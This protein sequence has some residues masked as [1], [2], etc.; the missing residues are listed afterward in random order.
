MVLINKLI[1]IITS[2]E[3]QF[4]LIVFAVVLGIIIVSTI[5]MS[6]IKKKNKY[7]SRIEKH[8]EF[9]EEDVF[10]DFQEKNKYSD[11]FNRYVKPYIKK[12]PDVFT[13]ILGTTGIDLQE[14][15]RKLLRANVR[16]KT[17]EQMAA[18][19][20]IGL[21]AGVFV[22]VATFPFMDYMGL[23]IGL[24]F[25]F[26]LSIIPFSRLDSRYNKRKDEIKDTLPTYLRLMANATSV[27]HTVEEATR[28]V[29]DRYNCI[30]S[31]EF[32]KVENEAKYS[33]NW[34]DALENM[35]FRND[36]DELYNLVSEIKISKEKGT[37][38]TELLLR[39]AEKIEV[40]KVLRSSEIARKKSTI[41]ILPIFLFLFAPLIGL[42]MLPAADIMMNS[43]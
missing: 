24:G 30:L 34:S 13:K 11:A 39:H 5:I 10:E 9:S 40:E 12:H 23:A 29:S 35:A 20:I 16:D 15:Q 21:F 8:R 38:I 31:E 32:K 1:S 41:L 6:N 33:N 42:I 37:P 19:K 22:C 2:I 14:I 3:F 36:V 28:R 43:F 7:V 18:L 25:Y 26:Y 17:P 4:A 27:G